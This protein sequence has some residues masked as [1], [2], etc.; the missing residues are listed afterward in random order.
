M[1]FTIH[2]DGST[3][4]INTAGKARE[5][6]VL[7]RD[8]MANAEAFEGETVVRLPRSWSRRWKKFT[9]RSIVRA[10]DLWTWPELPPDELRRRVPEPSVFQGRH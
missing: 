7:L 1:R 9:D 8:R 2:T 6:H 4:I 10:I 5:A 3:V